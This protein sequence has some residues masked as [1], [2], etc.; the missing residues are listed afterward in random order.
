MSKELE[1]LK[2]EIKNLDGKVFLGFVHTQVYG[3]VRNLNFVLESPNPE[4]LDKYLS[5]PQKDIIVDVWKETMMATQIMV[6]PWEMS[7]T[8]ETNPPSFKTIKEAEF[9]IRG[10]LKTNNPKQDSDP[11]F[12][13]KGIH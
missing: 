13:R 9:Y 10:I 4:Y 3:P 11:F 6:L 8:A 12:Y 7:L 1:T 5:E 2:N